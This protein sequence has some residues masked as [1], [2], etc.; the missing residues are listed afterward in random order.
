MG[1]RGEG[2]SANTEVLR[3]RWDGREREGCG[4]G[5]DEEGCGGSEVGWWVWRCCLFATQGVCEID[6]SGVIW[7]IDTAAQRHFETGDVGG[8]TNGGD[9]GE[10]RGQRIQ[11]PGFSLLQ[12]CVDRGKRI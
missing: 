9:R 3:C 6:A 4:G 2:L 10:A 5:K 7:W 1:L 11:K 12:P 8:G